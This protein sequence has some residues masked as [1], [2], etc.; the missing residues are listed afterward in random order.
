MLWQIYLLNT[1]QVTPDRYEVYSE[2]CPGGY[3][4]ARQPG[5]MAYQCQC[6]EQSLRRVVHCEEDQ[7]SIIIEVR[8]QHIKNIFVFLFSTY[9]VSVAIRYLHLE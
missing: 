6:L 2:F 9:I 5:F 7:D 4:I 8:Y 3:G 1:P